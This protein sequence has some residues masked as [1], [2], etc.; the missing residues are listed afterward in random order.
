MAVVKADVG[1]AVLRAGAINSTIVLGECVMAH[2]HKGVASKS[3]HGKPI[4]DIVKL[5]PMA[6]LG[7]DM[8][9]LLREIVDLPW[10][11]KD[12]ESKTN[13]KTV[14]PKGPIKTQ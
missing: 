10:P 14:Q 8:W 3:P 6:H 12:M 1:C 2:M 5:K 13:C 7:G 9:S 4:A 11:S